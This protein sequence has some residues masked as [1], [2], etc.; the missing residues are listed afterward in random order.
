MIDTSL[1]PKKM[2]DALR[3]QALRECDRRMHSA[4]I[5]PE[6]THVWSRTAKRISI[7]SVLSII[8]NLEF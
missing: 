8:F 7:Y 4:H 2:G 5:K 3:A 6:S 1:L